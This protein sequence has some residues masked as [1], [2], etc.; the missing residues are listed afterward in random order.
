MKVLTVV[1]D[2]GG[3]GKTTVAKFLS[4]YFAMQGRRVLGIDLDPQGNYS[5][6]FL[7]MIYDPL[8]PDGTAP[9]L[10]P[11]FEPEKDIDWPGISSSADIYQKG[12]VVPYPTR[13]ENLDVLPAYGIRMQEIEQVPLSEVKTR[14]HNLLREFLSY[15]EVSDNYDLVII[16][17]GPNKKP[18]TG[19]AVHA[20]THILIPVQMEPQAQ[21]KL[22][23]MLQLWRI[24]NQHRA[25]DDALIN[26]GILPNMF[27]RRLSIHEGMLENARSD[28]ATAPFLVPHVIH[29]YK[30]FIEADFHGFMPPSVLELADDN[31]AK[32]DALAVCRYVE[33]RLFNHG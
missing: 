24:E 23:S 4:E 13:Y 32:Q 26:I 15:P 28:P 6:R 11:E 29:E 21:E 30:D 17:T 27:R 14:V 20:A 2:K 9:P 22:N 33:E 31:R 10:H 16:D 18:L 5:A 19:S 7:E 12:Q 1:Q 3:V 8:D 25:E